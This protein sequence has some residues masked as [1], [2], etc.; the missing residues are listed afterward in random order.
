MLSITGGIIGKIGKSLKRHSK[1]TQS[2]IGQMIALI[3]ESISGLKIIQAFNARSFKQKQFHEL[4]KTIYTQANMINLRYELSSPLTE[5]L[6]ICVFSSVLWFGG[7]L[8]FESELDAATFI[9]FIAMFSLL[10]QPA[11]SFS[12]A[13]YNIRIGL[14]AAERVFE[15]LETE[16]DVKDRADAVVKDNFAASIS[17]S[18][19]G[20]RY[21][22]SERNAL[23]GVSFDIA[24]GQMIAIVGASGS[25]KTTLVDLLL[26]FHQGYS[27]EI[28]LDGT[29]IN[30][31]TID[32]TRNL[33]AVVS[34]EPVLFNDTIW[35]N[36]TFGIE[37]CTEEM[38][39]HAAKVANA[40]DF[41]LQLE[42]GYNT[43]IGDR[44]MRLSGGERQRITI[45]RAMLRNPPILIL[46]EATSSL[47]SASE[48]LVQDALANAMKERTVIA[49][50]HR[51]STIQHA[52]KIVVMHEGKI[53]ETGTHET[54]LSQ[55]GYYAKMIA[56]QQFD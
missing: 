35:N 43:N 38:V 16:S 26:R 23:N 29:D 17:F 50:A 56:L 51:L 53:V 37:N 1:D 21:A 12:N 46:D 2:T 47:D 44:G 13:F 31:F 18:N 34:Q 20:F 7:N 11:K 8:V 30:N 36:I 45:A 32:S 54:L 28:L 10:I 42:Q 4:N 41:I 9:G 24:K 22:N 52:H 27:G 14:A 33:M 40:H 25:G 15:V 5:F 6:S 19:L 48:K 39:M 55:N 49:I 3:E